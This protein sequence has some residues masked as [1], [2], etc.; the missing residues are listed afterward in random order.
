M[1]AQDGVATPPLLVVEPDAVDMGLGH[2]PNGSTATSV[3]STAARPPDRWPAYSI[4]ERTG[5]HRD[6][7]EENR[8]LVL[9]FYEEVWNR[10]NVS[11][12]GEVFAD[13][14]VRHDLR[15]TKALGIRR[16][17]PRLR[18]IDDRAARV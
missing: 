5:G 2:M 1:D 3:V 7:A 11:V 13:D 18:P 17:G 10:G 15:P 8:S 12:V 16:D 14:D 6:G 9:R 4:P